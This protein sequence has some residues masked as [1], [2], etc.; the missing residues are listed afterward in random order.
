MYG[1][2][3]GWDQK[4]FSRLGDAAPA[5]AARFLKGKTLTVNDI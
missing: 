1:A 4:H 5:A 2:Y 3:A